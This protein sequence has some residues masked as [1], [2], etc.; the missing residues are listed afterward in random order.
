MLNSSRDESNGMFTNYLFF[1]KKIVNHCNVQKP[2]IVLK[3]NNGIGKQ[4]TH[5]F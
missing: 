2:E 5:M 1:L 3:D 4:K